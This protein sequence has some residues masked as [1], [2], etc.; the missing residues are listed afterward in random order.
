MKI[1]SGNYS[2]DNFWSMLVNFIGMKV[3]ED[4]ME[5]LGIV[6]ICIHTYI[7]TYIHTVRTVHTVYSVPTRC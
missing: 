2:S 4:K 5:R 3:P 1:F 6:V 7:H